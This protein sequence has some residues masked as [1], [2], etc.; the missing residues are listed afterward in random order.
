MMDLLDFST[1]RKPVVETPPSAPTQPAPET[2][3]KTPEMDLMTPPE[4]ADLISMVEV[5]A[6]KP[7]EPDDLMSMTEEIVAP[8]P[9]EA[10]KA[11]EPKGDDMW[12][13]ESESAQAKP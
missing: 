11:P 1:P 13:F 10:A 9:M 6:P 2:E 12:I 3:T 7:V 8:A 4:P 5:E